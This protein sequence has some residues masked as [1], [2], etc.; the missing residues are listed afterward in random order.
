MSHL[1]SLDTIIAN[2]PSPDTR[3]WTASRK[4]SVVQAVN[5]GV[6]SADQAC[7]NYGMTTAELSEWLS[8]IEQFGM[9]GLRVTML[10]QYRRTG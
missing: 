5:A 6:I 10:Q 7:E 4:A 8:R 3:R 9:E 2:L 1:D